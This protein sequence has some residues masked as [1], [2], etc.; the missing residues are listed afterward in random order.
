MKRTTIGLAV[1]ASMLLLC[2][3]FAFAQ[4]GAT[5]PRRVTPA[6]PTPEPTAAATGTTSTRTAQPTSGGNTQA[7]AAGTTAHAL[8]LLNQKQYE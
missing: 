4:S 2:A 7:G 3:S 1:S 5:R 6:Q 8:S